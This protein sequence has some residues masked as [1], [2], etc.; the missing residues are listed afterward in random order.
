MQAQVA[1]NK[2]QEKTNMSQDVYMT[3]TV[4]SGHF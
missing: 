1:T 2:E 3:H 4:E